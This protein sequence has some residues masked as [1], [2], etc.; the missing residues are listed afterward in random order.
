M[1]DLFKGF[2]QLL[3]LAETLEEKIQ[4]GEL[5]A[6]VQVN[7]RPLSSIPRQSNIPRPATPRTYIGTTRIR[8]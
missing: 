8:T 1:N 2:D 7:T 6:D 5:K 3:E 4:S